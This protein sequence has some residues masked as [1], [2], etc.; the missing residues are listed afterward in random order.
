MIAI[1]GAGPAGSYL[2]Y[3]LAKRG[4]AVTIIEEHEKIGRPVQCTG[5]VT[6]SI[7]KFVKLRKDLVANRLKNVIVVSKN[8]KTKVGTEEIVLWRDKFDEF[9]AGMAADEGTNILLNHRFMGFNGKSSIKIK[10]KK[11]N[12]TKKIKYDFLVGADGVSSA[13]A[14][15]AGLANTSFYIGMQAKVKLKM[16][17]ETFETYFGSAF[18]NF[19]G[20]CVPESEEVVRLGLASLSKPKEHFYRFLKKRAGNK[21]IIEWQ[22]GLIPIYNP[23]RAIQKGNICLI[24][25]AA[26]QVKATTGGGIIPSLKAA[27]TLCNCI[28]NSKNYNKEFKSQSGKELLLHLK[29]RKILNRLSDRDYNYLLRLMDREKV[30]KILKKYDR[31]TAIPLV[32]NLLLKEPRFLLFSKFVL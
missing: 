14:K 17:P 10:N 27:K 23:K 29:I 4:T 12:K 20:W 7:E 24:G 11:N 6:P 26:T 18:P 19:F 30:K 2:A 8:Y 28:I 13:V 5:I 32:L 1:V 16:G 9:I 22:S 3:L 15:A 31:D 25:D 21:K